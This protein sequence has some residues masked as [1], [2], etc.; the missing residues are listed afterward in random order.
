MR[1]EVR[2]TLK[3]VR[4]GS[5]TPAA[6]VVAEGRAPPEGEVTPERVGAWQRL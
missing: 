6:G 1:K 2:T 3:E 5:G 4:P